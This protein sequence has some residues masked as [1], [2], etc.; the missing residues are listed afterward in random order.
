M[1]EID[2]ASQSTSYAEQVVWHKRLVCP[3]IDCA[4]E[5]VAP[6]LPYTALTVYA[7]YRRGLTGGHSGTQWQ[8]SVTW[9]LAG[10]M[11]QSF[12]VNMFQEL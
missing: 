2:S 11:Q 1:P 12:L 7:K 4:K 9:I 6:L 5:D 8:W 3:D 10:R